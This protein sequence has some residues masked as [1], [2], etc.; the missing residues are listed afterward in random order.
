M[1]NYILKD[2]ELCH[3]KYVFKRRVNGKWRYYY[4]DSPVPT[5]ST[6]KRN[7]TT[8]DSFKENTSGPNLASDVKKVKK[9]VDPIVKSASARAK[10]KINKLLKSFGDAI[11]S[12]I[13]ESHDGARKTNEY[14]KTSRR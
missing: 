9:T 1:S 2:G 7:R 11:I 4:S 10:N 12:T 13:R 5:T 6:H 14:L 3:Y 8:I